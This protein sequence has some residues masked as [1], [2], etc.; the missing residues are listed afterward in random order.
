[1]KLSEVFEKAT[2]KICLVHD[3]ESKIFYIVMDNK[4]NAVDQEF[5]DSYNQIL[6][7]IEAKDEQGMMITINKSPKVF[8]AGFNLRH[9]NKD[10]PRNMQETI[11]HMRLLL[12]RIMTLNLPTLAIINGHAIAGGAMLALAHDYAFMKSG[13]H[14]FF[15][16]EADI[17]YAV[18]YGMIRFI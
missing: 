16:N 12:A 13:K 14:K 10:W 9:W 15:L 4:V 8:S 6:D 2:G 18:P 3:S 1:M 5:L 11:A 7:V 17:G